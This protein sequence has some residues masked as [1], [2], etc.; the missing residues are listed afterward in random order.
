[1]RA[2][3]FSHEL[4]MSLGQ[5]WHFYG[6]DGAIVAVRAWRRAGRPRKDKA[7]RPIDVRRQHHVSYVRVRRLHMSWFLIIIIIM[8]II[9]FLIPFSLFLFLFYYLHVKRPALDVIRSFIV[10][11][12]MYSE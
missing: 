6:R 4:A 2:D 3:L 9:L 8:I 7:P 1:M 10:H 12:E 11:T 5:L